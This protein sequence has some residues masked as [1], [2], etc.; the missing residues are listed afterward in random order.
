MLHEGQMLDMDLSGIEDYIGFSAKIIEVIGVSILLVGTIWTLIRYTLLP[1]ADRYPK[2]RQQLG[3]TILLGLEV[4]VAADII[5]TV[6]TEPTLD[7]VV[8]L[9]LIVLIRTFLSISIQAEVE[10]KLPWQRRQE[11]NDRKV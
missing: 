3:R 1:G 10:G 2:L 9:G 4:L 5:A 11:K 7:R 6:V 8:T